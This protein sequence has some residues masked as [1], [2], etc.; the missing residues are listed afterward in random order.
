MKLLHALTIFNSV[1]FAH[2]HQTFTFIENLQQELNAPTHLF[3]TSPFDDDDDD[4]GGDDDD[5]DGDDDDDDDVLPSS[6]RFRAPRPGLCRS[7]FFGCLSWWVAI[8][9]A[10]ELS[11]AHALNHN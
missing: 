7:F 11:L 2:S 4:D 10:K 5:D 9:S 1:E 3:S 6:V 8:S